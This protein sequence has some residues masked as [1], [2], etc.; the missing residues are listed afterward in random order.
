[1]NFFY[2]LMFGAGASAIAYSTLARRVGY[3]NNQNMIIFLGVIFVFSTIV[4][5]TILQYILH[6]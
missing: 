6:V 2:A 1:M 3:G 4:F 5:F